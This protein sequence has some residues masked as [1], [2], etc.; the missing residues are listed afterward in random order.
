MGSAA[1]EKKSLK[2]TNMLFLKEEDPEAQQPSQLLAEWGLERK[3]PC[4]R[5]QDL[6]MVLGCLF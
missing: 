4:A 1:A 5:S 6:S 2:T 3:P